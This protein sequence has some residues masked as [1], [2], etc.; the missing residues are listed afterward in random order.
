MRAF[1]CVFEGNRS[2]GAGSAVLIRARESNSANKEDA[3]DYVKSEYWDCVK[4]VDVEGL[5]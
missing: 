1:D 3:N 4:I 2:P 5:D